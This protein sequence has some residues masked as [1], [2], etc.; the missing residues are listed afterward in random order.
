[1]N[2]I[3]NGKHS[4]VKS[5]SHFEGG[6]TEKSHYDKQMGKKIVEN[7]DVIP[8]RYGSFGMTKN[9]HFEGTEGPRNP[10][11][12]SKSAKKYINS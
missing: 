8:P 6:T 4:I 3:Q 2:L 12:A 11:T 7:Q 5:F 10:I 9:C 1:M